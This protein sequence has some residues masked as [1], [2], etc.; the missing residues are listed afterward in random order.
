M[1][2]KEIHMKEN[3]RMISNMDMESKSSKMGVSTMVLGEMEKLMALDC[4]YI[5]MEMNLKETS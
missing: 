2:I 3:G 1:T 5:L 4:F